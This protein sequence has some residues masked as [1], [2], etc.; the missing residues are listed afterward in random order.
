MNPSNNNNN[1]SP[2]LAQLVADI[3][4]FQKLMDFGLKSQIIVAKKAKGLSV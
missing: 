4:S 1:K 2:G 3:L